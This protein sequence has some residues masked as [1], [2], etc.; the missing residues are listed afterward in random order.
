M[1][2]LTL[3]AAHGQRLKEAGMDKVACHNECFVHTMREYAKRQC[4][5]YGMVTTDDLRM[6]A[7]AYGL[8]PNHPNA[9]G[10][11]LKGKGWTAI[12]RQPSKL[13]GNHHREIRVWKWS[14]DSQVTR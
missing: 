11:I 3:D 12:G 4:K 13:P 9:W 2:Q 1:T 8:Y 10:S 7:T 14:G 5:L 6:H